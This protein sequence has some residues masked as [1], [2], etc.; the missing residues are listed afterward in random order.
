MNVFHKTNQNYALLNLHL[1]LT[2]RMQ[3]IERRIN[4][5]IEKKRDKKEIQ[6][7]N[8]AHLNKKVSLIIKNCIQK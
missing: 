6:N 1:L 2:K 4:K 3:K 8:M 7:K 5:K